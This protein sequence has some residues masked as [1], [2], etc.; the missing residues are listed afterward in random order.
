MENPRLT[1]FLVGSG[2]IEPADDGWR[3]ILPPAS[4]YAD[5]QLDDTHGRPRGSLPHRPPLRLTLEARASST[6]PGGTL[7]FGFWNDPFPAWGGEGGARRRLPASPQA[8][9]FFHSS[10]PSHIPF[11]RSGPESGW[12]AATFKGPRLPG[13]LVAAVGAGGLVGLTLA[14]FRP[15]LLSIYWRLF[16]GEQSRPLEGLG[17]WHRYEIHWGIESVRFLV[18]EQVVLETRVV[19]RPPLGLVIWIDNQWA[20]LST[21]GAGFG[22]VASAAPAWLEVRRLRIDGVRLGTVHDAAERPSPTPE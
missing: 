13:V 1:R 11:A 10:P 7:G 6:T 5:A 3:M 16:A 8:L 9:W 14:P 12:T 21:S 17:D 22:V 18:D 20:S 15:L 19:P 4:H 2:R